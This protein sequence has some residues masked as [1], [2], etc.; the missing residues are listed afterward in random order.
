[1]VFT[2]VFDFFLEQILC[3]FLDI[4]VEQGLER[5]RKDKDIHYMPMC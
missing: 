2:E 3:F 1:M 5:H 4:E